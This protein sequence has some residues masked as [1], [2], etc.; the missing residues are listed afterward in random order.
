ML[1]FNDNHNFERLN[2][3]H[4]IL[5]PSNVKNKSKTLKIALQ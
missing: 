2:V 4:T 1:K 5:Q 3:F